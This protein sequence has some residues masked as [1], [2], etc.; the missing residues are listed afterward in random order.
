VEVVQEALA[1]ADRWQ[2]AT[3]AFIEIDYD[4]AT[5]AAAAADANLA[6]HP[7]PG[8]LFGAPLAYKD[9]FD[10]P[11]Q[12]CSYG[13][14]L[15]QEAPPER[16][17]VAVSQLEAAGGICVGVLNMSEFA[18]G[19]T[20]HNATFGHTR[21]PWSRDHVAGG[22]SS[23]A[24]AAAACGVIAGALGSDTGG[25]IRIPAACCGVVGLK[26][27]QDGV[28]AWGAMPLSPS[29][30]CIGPIAADAEDCETLFNVLVSEDMRFAPTRPAHAL[31][32]AFP[33][34]QIA[35]ELP[36]SLLAA[37]L[38]AVEVFRDSGLAAIDVTL[39]DISALHRLAD[40]IQR[41]ES[42]SSHF[43]SL[44]SNRAAYTPH[45]RRRIEGG[46]FISAPAYIQALRQRPEHRRAM[47]ATVFEQADVLLLPTLGVEVPRI[48]STDEEQIG[49]I[50]EL[51]GRMTRWTRWINYL[52][53]PALSV[54]CGRDPS[55]LPVGLQLVAPP[56][57]ERDL[58]S[59]AKLFQQTA[60]GLGWSGPPKH[61]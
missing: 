36:Q 50:P 31:R 4:S 56:F 11:G 35:R 57:R 21:N 45:V 48:D 33:Q 8:P 54:P 37:L 24:G 59:A 43:E 3:N 27:T 39:P 38:E 40:V 44:R 1:A 46:L 19:P 49:Q 5:A 32:L 58:F 15:G 6:R 13:S 51:V 29:L 53:L 12:T 23:G 42:L 60:P 25:S 2:P 9:M 14:S 34:D 16:A 7:E 28:D 20:G 17:A 41:P 47:I 18:L 52:G 22:S 55:N 26:P 30:D 10:R 61:P